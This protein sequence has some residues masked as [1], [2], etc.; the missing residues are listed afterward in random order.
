MSKSTDNDRIFDLA[1][2]VADRVP[3]GIVDLTDQILEAINVSR[4][5]LDEDGD[6]E[7]DLVLSIPIAVKW[8][9]DKAKVEVSVSVA[10]K[11]K[12]TQEFT[13]KDPN[14]PELIDREGKPI[15]DSV[16]NGLRTIGRA[17][18]AHGGTVS[19]EP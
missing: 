14:Q 7:K 1:Q 6:N 17:L 3:K 2:A 12:V 13:L 5:A 10:V 15:P 4:E 11:H 9:F 8:N 19:T 16:A 18:K